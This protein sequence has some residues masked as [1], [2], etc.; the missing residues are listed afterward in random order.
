MSIFG[1]GIDVV[2]VERIASSMSE[3]GDRFASK[4][5]TESERSY[6]E[7]QNRPAIHYA[8]RF[9]AKEAV[10]KALG[11][12]IGKDLSW[13]DIEIRRRGSGEPEV[14]LSGDGEKFAKVNNLVQIKISL[15]H[16][17]HYA[18]ANAVALSGG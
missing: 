4:V 17:Q 2:E 13:L 10:A 9:A 18:A 16:A 5:F 6:C 7:S 11:T 8:A 15:T 12:G 14:F 1:I 3:F